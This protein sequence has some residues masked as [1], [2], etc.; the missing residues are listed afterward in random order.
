MEVTKHP[1]RA[2]ARLFAGQL[3]TISLPTNN[4]TLNDFD[5]HMQEDEQIQEPT[6][7][8]VVI[9]GIVMEIR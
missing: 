2:R 8:V 3:F 4:K 7:T 5:S 9:F 1:G 6:T